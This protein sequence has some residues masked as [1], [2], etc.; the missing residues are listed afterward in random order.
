MFAFFKQ[1]RK[2]IPDPDDNGQYTQAEIDQINSRN[3]PIMLDLEQPART[4]FFVNSLQ[5]YDE[6]SQAQQ[7][8]PSPWDM[9]T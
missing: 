8:K 7:S 9:N 1:H 5:M 3:P 4:Q 6:A 2:S